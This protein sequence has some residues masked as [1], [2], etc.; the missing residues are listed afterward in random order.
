MLSQQ[1]LELRKKNSCILCLID[2]KPAEINENIK[3]SYFLNNF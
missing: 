1:M 2:E 3:V